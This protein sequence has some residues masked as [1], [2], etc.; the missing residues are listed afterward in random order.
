MIVTGEDGTSKPNITAADP[1]ANLPS[2][3][4]DVLGGSLT[5]SFSGLAKNLDLASR[6]IVTFELA[7]D[8]VTFS[9][10]FR[11][12][13]AELPSVY[14]D[15]IG[16][17]RLVGMKQRFYELPV[18]ALRL[19]QADVAAMVR[20][21]ITSINMPVGTSYSSS[22]V[23][24]LGF[25]NGLRIPQSETIG[26][27]LDSLARLVGR[28]IV[29]PS[30]TYTYDGLTYNAGDAVPAVRWGVTANGAFFFRRP[31]PSTITLNEDATD[32][33][34]EW[35]N[36]VSEESPNATVL[37]FGQSYDT[38]VFN[39]LSL[40]Y[41]STSI[42]ATYSS[43]ATQPPLALAMVRELGSGMSAPESERRYRR[44]VVDNPFELL[45]LTPGYVI[46]G[47]GF[48]NLANA[49]DGDATT[50]AE[51]TGTPNTIGYN[52]NDFDGVRECFIYVDYSSDQVVEVNVSWR[53]WTIGNFPPAGS[54]AFNLVGQLP[55]TDG[56][57]NQVLLFVGT[58]VDVPLSLITYIRPT[59]SNFDVGARVYRFELLV[60]DV[61]VGGGFCEAVA[62]SFERPIPVAA[63]A[64][65][66]FGF[67]SLA[68][69]V[70]VNPLV[71]SPVNLSVE[72][73]DYALSTSNGVQTTYR[74]SSAYDS[75]SELERILLERL[76]RRAVIEGGAT[77]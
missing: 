75:S 22:N 69:T 63:S 7:E 67:G 55:S 51:V 41:S 15:N 5:A 28:F 54:P 6:D 11:G 31:V 62:E 14:A 40:F 26:D 29:A 24:D 70:T 61:D 18:R 64:A 56:R 77:R 60:P 65:T 16:T 38:Q 52:R 68:T 10:V 12:Y 9:Q 36:V 76:A 30:S 25:V 17:Y 42:P 44:V 71:L 46:G 43:I 45:D 59:L 66:F 32:I 35:L 50:Y 48:S 37:V 13:V 27:F 58:P 3:S 49:A 57:R 23:P 53:G 1:I 33:D 47:Q 72:R 34:I 39:T 74:L 73:V 8:G 4:V 19:V 20:E 2:F 21:V